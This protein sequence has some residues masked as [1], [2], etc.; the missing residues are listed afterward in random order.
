MC[1]VFSRSIGLVGFDVFRAIE[2]P[3]YDPRG[4]W[5]Y[6]VGVVFVFTTPL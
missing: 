2:M 4:I 1:K 5:T 3:T 6:G